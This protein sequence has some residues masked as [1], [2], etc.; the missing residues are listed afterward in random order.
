MT[1]VPESQIRRS[2]T[3]RWTRALPAVWLAVAGAWASAGQEASPPE[4]LVAELTGRKPARSRTPAEWLHDY[5]RVVSALLPGIGDEDVTRR[6]QPQQMLERICLYAGRPGAGTQRG[7][8]ARVLARHLGD[9][10]PAA[11][12]VWLLRQLQHIGRAEC[13]DAVAALLTDPDPH[14][15]EAARRALQHNPAPLAGARLRHALQQAREPA[16]RVALIEALGPRGEVEAVVPLLEAASDDDPRVAAAALAALGDLAPAFVR[17]AATH[18]RLL[19]QLDD[20]LGL[21]ESLRRNPATTQPAA[22][23]GG[24]ASGP[25]LGFYPLRELATTALLRYAEA[26]EHSPWADRALVIW[27]RVL[28]DPLAALQQRAAALRGIT[29]LDPRDAEPRLYDLLK[30]DPPEPLT[31]TAVRA[32]GDLPGRRGVALG[33]LVLPDAPPAT[34]VMLAG[35]LADLGARDASEA[36]ARLLYSKQA[37]VRLAALEALARLGDPAQIVRL[38]RHAARASGPEREAARK[39]LARVRGDDAD[40]RIL[41]TALEQD[42]PRV[43][44]ELILSLGPRVARETIPALLELIG[45]PAPQQSTGATCPRPVD[46]VVR[47]A[48]WKSLARLAAAGHLQ[49]LLAALLHEDDADVRRAA[50]DALVRVAS[51]SE[52]PIAR[53]QPVIAAMTKADP[54]ARAALVRVLARL[55]GVAALDAVRGRLADDDLAV[56]EAALHAL[57]GWKTHEAMRDLLTLA[58]G[59]FPPGPQPDPDTRRAWR[60]VAL[61]GYLRLAR[62]FAPQ[63][64]PHRLRRLLDVLE[65]ARGLEQ[66][67]AWLSAL[68]TVADPAA[69]DVALKLLGPDSKPSGEAALAIIAIADAVAPADRTRAVAAL[70]EVLAAEGLPEP[71]LERAGETLDRIERHAADLARWQYAGPYACDGCNA[72][73]LFGVPF[74]PEPG[75]PDGPVRW[76]VLTARSHDDPWVFDFTQI[77]REPHRCIYVRTRLESPDRRDAV[78]HLGSDDGVKVWLNGRLVH[79][80]LVFRPVRAGEDTVRIMLRQ[81]PN[82]LLLKVVQGYGGWGFACSLTDAA[83]RPFDD[84]RL[85]LPQD[86]DAPGLLLRL[87]DIGRALHAVP[88]LP[89]DAKPN[90]VR[91]VATPDLAGGF[92]DFLPLTDQLVSE[93]IGNLWIPR[94]GNYGFELRSDDGAK[95]WIDGQLVIDHD[96]LHGATPR[97]GR[98]ALTAGP[99][100][101]YVRH[102]EAWGGEQLTLLWRTPGA[103]NDDFRPILPAALTCPRTV[104]RGT[105]PGRKSVLSHLRA[106]LPGDATPVA[107]MHPALRPAQPEAGESYTS[108]IHPRIRIAQ[109][110]PKLPA[111]AL[112]PGDPLARVVTTAGVAGAT[113]VWLPPPDA[114]TPLTAPAVLSLEGYGSMLLVA[115]PRTGEVFRVLPQ[116]AGGC[117]MRFAML[118]ARGFTGIGADPSTGK[119]GVFSDRQITAVFAPSGVTAFELRTIE[120]RSDGLSLEFTQP[121]DPRVGWEPDSY[122]VELW[123]LDARDPGAPPERPGHP[124]TVRQ[125]SVSPDRTRVDLWIPDLSAPAVVYLRLLPPCIDASLDTPWT[126]EAWLTVGA[127]PADPP[128]MR[129]QPPPQP[130]QN[131]LSE[132]EQ[133]EGWELLFDGR[134]TRGWRGFR[135]QGM[136]EG[137]QV[138]RGALVR[139]AP[140]GDV[141]SEQQFEDFELRFQWRISLGGNSGVFY[142]VS[143]DEPYVWRTGPEYQILDNRLH[144]DGRNP[145]T[146]A[147]ACYALYAPLRDVTRPVGLWNDARIVVRGH[148][149]EH[150]LNGVKVVEYEIGSPDFRQ[151]V[152]GSKFASMPKFAAYR[153]GHIALQDHGDVVGYRN[154]KIRRLR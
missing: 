41:D 121:L 99:H 20:T 57:A 64:P 136:P 152:A 23:G 87:Y 35:L 31:P 67:P 129:R 77:S 153:R 142:H 34:Q 47:I 3:R 55:G 81:G 123:P 58:R 118:E 52:Q 127:L 50:E 29:R 95:L 49:A 120:A 150:W 130:A 108:R 5:E 46:P 122:H 90:F 109:P 84:L 83:G 111:D 74:A 144:P 27:Q 133:V 32:A 88:E 59:Q 107:G 92:G 10:L 39:A 126:T 119:L 61:R 116:D 51:S 82:E 73:R 33:L 149:V 63:V 132:Q 80:H 44:A 2:P 148:H 4:A 60:V 37:R 91:L 110:A 45:A 125:A 85:A 25:A 71:L 15:R 86:A 104:S 1:R 75:G 98:L 68:G 22:A 12:K 76:R 54:P 117:V 138:V 96:G 128:V 8:L 114:P 24:D 115:R 14:V 106:G 9:P 146:S 40:Q 145:R 11:A 94:S 102:F 93:L 124:L 151:R 69:L 100:R 139:V 48:A 140:A 154:I 72:E 30:A 7:A 6:Q 18:G 131:V 62:S 17:T 26:L 135:K 53:V 70:G 16:W 19:Q 143:E 79:S 42:D 134:T 56:R 137:W 147:A 38:A 141:I 97:R 13:V 28:Q 103:E 43:A 113:T 21:L 78:L 65:P 112:P 36:V 66:M 101:L 89:A 105:Q